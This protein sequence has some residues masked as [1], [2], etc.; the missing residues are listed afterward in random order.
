MGGFL[1]LGPP[2]RREL[3]R[4]AVV[5]WA[6]NPTAPASPVE[7]T[8]PSDLVWTEGVPGAGFLTG[9]APEGDWYFLPVR[10]GNPAELRFV[11]SEATAQ[12]WAVAHPNDPRTQRGWPS[13]LG[14]VLDHA[15][16]MRVVEHLKQAVIERDLGAAMVQAGF[17]EESPANDTRVFR[18][19]LGR[20][21]DFTIYLAADYLWLMFQRNGANHWTNLLRVNTDEP[22][23]AGG[24]RPILWPP[25][26]AHP[27]AAAV[28]AALVIADSWRPEARQR[29]RPR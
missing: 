2:K 26:V 29:P 10:H 25:Q 17:Q 4:R 21:G 20:T 11:A 9:R 28:S 7:P 12:A 19:D 24:S 6:M 15:M 22:L 3:A 1:S 16:G 18:R 23:H 27:V 5:E 13:E 8:P 14:Y